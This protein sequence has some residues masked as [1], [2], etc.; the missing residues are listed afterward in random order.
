MIERE[1]TVAEKMAQLIVT[2]THHMK[3]MNITNIEHKDIA[4]QVCLFGFSF[5]KIRLK[6]APIK[7]E[8][9]NIMRVLAT[10]V[11]FRDKI[12]VT[13]VNETIIAFKI[14]AKPIA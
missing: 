11:L 4:I 8:R 6:K 7:G 5:K 1:E 2:T 9:L 12:K 3:K 13:L 10:F 14:P